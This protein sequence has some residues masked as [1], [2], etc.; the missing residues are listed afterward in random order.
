VLAAIALVPLVL[1]AA[2]MLR[3]F[4]GLMHGPEV[5]DLPQR[6]DLTALEF[7]ALAPLVIAIVLLGVDPA[8]VTAN[9]RSA[10]VPAVAQVQR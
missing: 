6:I 10:P 4:Q 8:P 1:A 2:Y 5:E 7:C 3:L 9:V